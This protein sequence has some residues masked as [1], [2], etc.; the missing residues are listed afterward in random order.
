MQK[1]IVRIIVAAV[2]LYMWGFL[3][4]G[5]SGI[6]Y[7]TWKQPTGSDDAIQ[8]ALREHF[9]ED[10]TYYVPGMY[11]SEPDLNRL[12]EQGPAAFVHIVA[13][14][15]RPLM[16]PTIMIGGFFLCLAVSALAA[17]LLKMARVEGF[18]RRIGFVTL[19][20]LTVAVTAHLGDVVWWLIS[21][22]WKAAQF[23]YETASFA[24]LGSILGRAKG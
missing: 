16:V 23:F 11:N 20:G 1:T 2:A 6:P 9:P 10:G 15:G 13:R 5:A 12:M 24:L 17:G 7:S 8:A 18:G 21:L 22:Q 4:W 14:D 19:V 3:Y